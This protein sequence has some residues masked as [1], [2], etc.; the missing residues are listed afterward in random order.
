[1]VMHIDFSNL[2]WKLYVLAKALFWQGLFVKIVSFLVKNSNEY[3]VEMKETP[4]LV[5]PWKEMDGVMEFW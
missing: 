4:V 2:N 5:E 3:H 1:M